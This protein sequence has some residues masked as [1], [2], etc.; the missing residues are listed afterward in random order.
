MSWENGKTGKTQ[1][2][3]FPLCAVTFGLELPLGT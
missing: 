2:I 1:L 3:R